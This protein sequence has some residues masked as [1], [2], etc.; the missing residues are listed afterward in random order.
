[1]EDL[2]LNEIA[3]RIVDAVLEQRVLNREEL[4]KTIR[5]LLSIWTKRCN[6]SKDR[7]GFKATIQKLEKENSLRINNYKK[8]LTKENTKQNGYRNKLIE[9]IGIDKVRALDDF[10]NAL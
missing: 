10:L 4:I 9:V 5:P 8:K 3:D 1:M 2:S 7:E 6:V